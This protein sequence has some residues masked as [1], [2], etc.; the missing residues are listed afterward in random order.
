LS[1]S[2]AENIQRYHEKLTREWLLKA[3]R[4][5]EIV[6]VKNYVGNGAQIQPEDYEY[7]WI[8]KCDNKK[9]TL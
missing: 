6:E 2:E 4:E 7:L 3:K 1:N 9:I 8:S 5:I